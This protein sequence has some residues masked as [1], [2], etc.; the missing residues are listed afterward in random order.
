MNGNKLKKEREKERMRNRK[1]SE[2]TR[3]NVH[4]R[5]RNT[6]TNSYMDLWNCVHSHSMHDFYI[7]AI[8]SMVPVEFQCNSIFICGVTTNDSD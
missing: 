2:L 7:Y 8:A 4:W 6:N 3:S 1:P 5:M